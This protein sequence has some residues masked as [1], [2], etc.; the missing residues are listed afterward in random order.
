[1]TILSA[2]H[3]VSP[4]SRPLTPEEADTRRVSYSIKFALAPSADVAAAAIEM[5]RLINGP[6]WLIPVP[7]CNGNTD[8]NARLARLIAEY[9][10]NDAR[11]SIS[12]AR[13]A[14][15]QSSCERHRLSLPPIKPAQHGFKRIGKMLKA[16]PTYLVDN[17]TTSGNTLQAAR[18]AI[19]FGCGL[20]FADAYDTLRIAA[21]KP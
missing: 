3:Y 21:H 6:C 11:V 5:A 16:L 17:V 15:V 10:R 1:M 13:T 2:R 7:N 19:G 8:A 14:P 9:A 20:V 18:D 4:R 12:L